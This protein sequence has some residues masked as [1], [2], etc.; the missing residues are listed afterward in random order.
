[1][2]PGRTTS[3]ALSFFCSPPLIFPVL[4]CRCLLWQGSSTDKRSS[5]SKGALSARFLW[6]DPSKSHAIT[7]IQLRAAPYYRKNPRIVRT[8][9]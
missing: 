6:A 8:R 4:W 2:L 9:I 1:M 7:G 3:Y 5:E